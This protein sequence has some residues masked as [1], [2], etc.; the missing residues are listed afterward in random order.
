MS[1]KISSDLSGIEPATFRLA[2]KYLNQL[3]HR[4]TRNGTGLHDISERCR[5]EDFLILTDMK[6]RTG[7]S[8]N[9]LPL[10]WDASDLTNSDRGSEHS[11]RSSTNA[12]ANEEGRK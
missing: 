10:Y 4:L 5:N 2:V 1:M 9:K 12:V 6:S 11:D 8:A 7:D 3:R